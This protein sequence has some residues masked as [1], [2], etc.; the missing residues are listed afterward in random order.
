[1][2][3]STYAGLLASV[4]SWLNRDDLTA[5]IPD[6]V[7]LA[8]AD[9]NNRLR[10]RAMLTTATV[11]ATGGTLPSDCL[12]VKSV[13]LSGYDDLGF[14]TPGEAV[15]HSLAYPGDTADR[16]SVDGNTL[17]ISP[18]QT[19]G[20]VTLRYYA[21]IPAL[22]ADNPTNHVL[23]ASPAIYL[24]GSLLQA[25]PYLLD[26]ARMQTWGTLYTQACDA[27]QGADDAAEYPGPLVIRASQW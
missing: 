24:Y 10:L 7:A 2:G 22:S 23:T 13:G 21:R 19:S 1:M 15:T 8:E 27:L 25:A 12:A 5:T 9:M 16:W 11:N 3:L 18:T 6:F 20:S 17:V 4:A 26:D 14:G